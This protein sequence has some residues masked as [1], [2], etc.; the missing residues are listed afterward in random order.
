MDIHTISN[1]FLYLLFA[2]KMKLNVQEVAKTAKTMR[3]AEEAVQ[4]GV[5]DKESTPLSGLS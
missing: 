2:L 3:D 4:Q 1:T 5:F